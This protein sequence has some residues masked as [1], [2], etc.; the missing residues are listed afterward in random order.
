MKKTRYLSFLVSL[1]LASALIFSGCSNDDDEKS[2]DTKSQPD[3]EQ[4]D[5]TKQTAVF[6]SVDDAAFT[7]LRSLTDLTQYDENAVDDTDESGTTTY[8]GI[9]TL[10]EN[11]NTL[12]F[13]CDEGFVL[14]ETKETVRS[15]SVNGFGDALEFFSGVIGENLTEDSLTDGTYK[16]SY[17]GLGSLTFKK[18]S[19]SD[20]NL[21]ATLDVSLS[22]MPELTQL[23]F[24]PAAI[25]EQFITASNKY[26][27]KP[28]Y[29]AG[30]VIK[31]NSDDTYWICVR[32]AGG[33]YYKD[34]SYWI[35]LDS[36]INS[37]KNVG[38]TT[39]KSET[40][41]VKVYYDVAEKGKSEYKQFTQ[42][43]VYAKNLMSLKVAKAAFHTFS[44]LVEP[45]AWNIKGY[46][47][48]QK[49][50]ETLKDE[51][52]IDLL[53]L[54][55]YANSENGVSEEF[56]QKNKAFF[57]HGSFCFAYG[58]P[59]NESNRRLKLNKPDHEFYSTDPNVFQKVGQVD[60]IQPFFTAETSVSGGTVNETILTQFNNGEKTIANSTYK[61][62]S[63]LLSLTDGFDGVFVFS[64]YD[65]GESFATVVGETDEEKAQNYLYDFKNFLHKLENPTLPVTP[66]RLV[67][68]QYP[69]D[70]VTIPGIYWSRMRDWHVI[71]SP[72][73]SLADNA[74]SETDAVRPSA[75]KKYT[76]LYV[77]GSAKGE[78]FDYWTTFA[79][80]ARTIDKKAVD[81]AKESKE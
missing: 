62:K 19:G 23:R 24:V 55:R 51:H 67:Y 52:N 68:C 35:S 5:E 77:Q 7:V 36:F 30:D 76:D 34:N 20:D 40:K 43:W 16:W 28:Y 27:G 11:W 31:R 78:Y 48:A 3:S 81:W 41:T 59:K 37:G 50:Y 14:D 47:N 71:V 54:N 10:P 21:Y 25:V 38:Q 60:H 80:C 74:G 49:V 18:A 6:D 13:S 42:Q 15:L 69:E 45:E 79:Q 58:S 73:L 75:A 1:L 64:L 4:T 70:G 9:E 46:E 22:V 32:P 63:F 53:G 65:Q 72:E 56:K 26:K 33:P 57:L 12:T 8:S 29:H 44:S 39:I 66:G 17:D 2:A 61:N